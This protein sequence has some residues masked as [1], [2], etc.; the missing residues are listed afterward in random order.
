MKRR[1]LRAGIAGGGWPGQ[2][3]VEG[4]LASGEWEVAAVADLDPGRR[5]EL[6]HGTGAIGLANAQDLIDRDDLDAVVIALPTFLHHPMVMAALAAGKHVLCEKPP[7]LNARETR[8]DGRCRGAQRPGPL[9]RS[10]A[11]RDA[12]G[13]CRAGAG[14]AR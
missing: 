11:T 13:R 2:R 10:A 6:A 9:L 8:R 4:L 7:A 12:V 1:K 3:H 5:I 14:R